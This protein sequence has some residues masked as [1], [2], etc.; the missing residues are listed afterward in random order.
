MRLF[1]LGLSTAHQFDARGARKVAQA[2]KKW[3]KN[4]HTQKNALDL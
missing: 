3:A 1:K 4:F 2:A